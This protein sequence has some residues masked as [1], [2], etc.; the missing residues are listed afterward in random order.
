MI[1]ER[2]KYKMKKWVPHYD[3]SYVEERDRIKYATGYAQG[4][5]FIKIRLAV[6]NELNI[7]EQQKQELLSE[8]CPGWSDEDIYRFAYSKEADREKGYERLKTDNTDIWKKDFEKGEKAYF[9]K[10]DRKEK[11]GKMQNRIVHYAERKKLF[12]NKELE[13]VY[14]Y[15]TVITMARMMP[16]YGEDFCYAAKCLTKWKQLEEEELLQIARIMEFAKFNSYQKKYKEYINGKITEQEYQALGGERMAILTDTAVEL[17]YRMYM[18]GEQ[19]LNEIKNI[20]KEITHSINKIT[21]AKLIDRI[22]A[23]LQEYIC[24]MNEIMDSGIY[25]AEVILQILGYPGMNREE[26][27]RRIN[28]M[29]K[30]VR[31]LS[32]RYKPTHHSTQRLR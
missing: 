9:K 13:K 1:E 18:N 30:D 5:M 29:E 2:R 17:I 10:R 20:L 27:G 14:H 23:V 6:K 16:E 19:N 4:R 32:K 22:R 12:K 31:E 26:Y 11:Y 25:P 3:S 7:T 8:M 28:A 15:G 21:A 24:T